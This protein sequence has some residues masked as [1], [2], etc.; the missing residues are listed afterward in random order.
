MRQANENLMVDVE[1]S[2][3]ECTHHWV[4]ET[5]S[6]P[7]SLGY[8]K[9][10]GIVKEFQNFIENNPNWEDDVESGQAQSNQVLRSVVT[11]PSKTDESE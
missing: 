1:P 2:Y 6:G 7:A 5:P 9:V 3:S 10:C 4:I 11:L 8:C